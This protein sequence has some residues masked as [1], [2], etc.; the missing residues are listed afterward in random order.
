MDDLV[1][2]ALYG[3]PAEI[4]A[5]KQRLAQS[6]RPQPLTAEALRAL[7][8][9]YGPTARLTSTAARTGT[10]S[11]GISATGTPS[12]GTGP[13]STTSGT[14]SDTLT[15]AEVFRAVVRTAWAT[16]SSLPDDRAASDAPLDGWSKALSEQSR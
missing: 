8:R 10:P 9:R 15:P 2:Q 4:Y 7:G 16:E 1:M 11:G 12:G 6:S 5:A 14:G 3:T 13:S